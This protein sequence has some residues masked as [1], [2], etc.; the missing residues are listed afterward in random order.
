VSLD[1]RL[2]C[3]VSIRQA[4]VLVEKARAIAGA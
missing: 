2:I 3:Y 1:G 4:Q